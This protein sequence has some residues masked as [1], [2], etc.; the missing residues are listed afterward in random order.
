MK[1]KSFASIPNACPQRAA[2]PQELLEPKAEL[3]SSD[4]YMKYPGN[5]S[6]RFLKL[7]GRPRLG[8]ASHG[9]LFHQLQD[10]QRHRRKRTGSRIFSR[11][12]PIR[13]C[14]R[15]ATPCVQLL[16]GAPPPLRLGPSGETLKVCIS[17]P[18]DQPPRPKPKPYAPPDPGLLR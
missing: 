7:T 18:G 6:A 11:L 2:L 8:A 10:K 13:G 5:A 1:S 14:R 3:L 9:I 12:R 16:G 17:Q 4:K 15:F